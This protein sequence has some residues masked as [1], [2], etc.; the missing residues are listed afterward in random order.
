[1][2]RRAFQPA[3]C[4]KASLLFA[5]L[6]IRTMTRMQQSRKGFCFY[7]AKSLGQSHNV[8][9][10]SKSWCIFL[11]HFGPLVDGRLLR[12]RL[13][14]IGESFRRRRKVNLLCLSVIDVPAFLCGH[15]SRWKG[16]RIGIP[17]QGLSTRARVAPVGLLRMRRL[18]VPTSFIITPWRASK[19]IFEGLR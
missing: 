8:N 2:L 17:G 18:R 6:D 10:D 13:M 11:G 4:V 7:R 9:D 1:M 14:S 12:Q 15:E 19:I 5:P 3:D 16:S